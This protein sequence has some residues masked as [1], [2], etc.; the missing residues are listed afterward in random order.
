MAN[1]I[2]WPDKL[3]DLLEMALNDF[4]ISKRSRKFVPNM[5]VFLDKYGSA[6]IGC[7]AG[8][9]LFRAG[10]R[11]SEGF[12]EDHSPQLCAIDAMRTGN[13]SLA[14]S[15]LLKSDVDDVSFNRPITPYET[16]PR[17]FYVELRRLVKDLRAAGK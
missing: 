6:C 16:S 4:V 1:E 10:F 14:A 5:A 15:Y 9:V 11:D 7:L 13:V 2:N 8:G 17:R 3:S 12:W